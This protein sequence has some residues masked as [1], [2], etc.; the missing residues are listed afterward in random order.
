MKIMDCTLRDG[1]NVVGKGFPADLTDMILRGLIQNG[2]SVIEYGNAGGIGAYEVSNYIAPLT[3]LEYLELAQPYMDKAEIGMFLNAK[4]CREKNVALG[5]EKGLSFLR[6]GAD[7]GESAISIPAVKLV[8]QYGLKAQYSLMKAYVLPPKELAEEGRRLQDA[9]VDAMTIM[10][11]AGTMT[12]EMTAEYA[13]TLSQ[14]VSVPVGF[15]SHNNLGLAVANAQAAAEHGAQLI[16]CGLLGMARS[17]GNIATELAVA[18]LQRQ[19][20]AT[21]VD[22]FGL[23]GFLDRELIP[24]MAEHNYRPA[25]TPEE[26]VLGYA[27]CHSSFMKQLRETAKR[28]QVDLYRLIVEVSRQDR[29][30]PSQELMDRIADQL[31]AEV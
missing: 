10:D 13:E 7:A 29:K 14:A 8:K 30:A 2:V 24:A 5:A 3:D 4:R 18:V 6:V 28:K 19:G 11:S 12:P 16:D 23:L 31:A 21:E 20:M 22:L 26:L 25:V 15:H 17:A 1:A 27:G 9:G